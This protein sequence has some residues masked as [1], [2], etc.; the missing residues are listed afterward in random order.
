[1]TLLWLLSA[2]F[3]CLWAGVFA[4][5]ARPLAARWREPVL[6]YPVL[7]IESDDW[8][9]GPLA[10]ADLLARLA[11][12]LQRMRDAAGRPAVMTLGMVMEVPDGARIAADGGARPRRQRALHGQRGVLDVTG[13]QI[14]VRRHVGQHLLGECAAID[15]Q[16]NLHRA[17]PLKTGWTRTTV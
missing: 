6:K 9:A 14:Q 7:A 5:F 16:Q 11:A 1:M 10:Q 15:S 2:G 3:A 13:K 17:D 12:C 8:G 4:A